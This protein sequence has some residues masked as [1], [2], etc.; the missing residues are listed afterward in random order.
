MSGL[1]SIPVE[2]VHLIA[3]YLP[4]DDLCALR[5]TCRDMN[6][7]TL[8][9]FA[10]R[11]FRTRYV[12]LERESLNTLIRISGHPRLGPEVR[13]LGF[14]TERLLEPDDGLEEENSFWETV[15][16]DM[17]G[18]SDSDEP[19]GWLEGERDAGL[20]PGDD[21][22]LDQSAAVISR[23]YFDDQES[24]FSGPDVAAL[25]RAMSGL[26]NCKTLLLTDAH[27]PWGAVRMEREVGELGRGLAHDAIGD[28]SFVK[29]VI[30]VMLTAAR[31]SQ[32]PVEELCIELGKESKISAGDPISLHLLDSPPESIARRPDSNHLIGLTTLKLIASPVIEDES[33]ED[34]AA[35]GWPG[36]FSRFLGLF[37]QLSH[38][39]L[40]FSGDFDYGIASSCLLDVLSLPRLRKLELTRIDTVEAQ[41]TGFLLR[42]ES[43]LEEVVLDKVKMTGRISWTTLLEKSKQM[44]G[45]HS[46]TLKDCWLFYCSRPGYMYDYELETV[47]MRNE[48]DFEH[49]IAMVEG[50]GTVWD[51]EE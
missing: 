21:G 22:F 31:E 3:A 36:N 39:S 51:V 13:T 23:R 10:R 14:C 40:A 33:E 8:G 24:F 9:W 34:E 11:Y 38:F 7:K 29:H 20:W 41:L 50:L 43:T 18:D 48:K 35:P 17:A 6:A 30:D 32:L 2:T 25:T 4:I 15:A 19:D 28:E 26:Y 44:P 27:P 12:M 47:S 16:G 5:L 42:H 46:M 1:L 49:A 37:P 45:V